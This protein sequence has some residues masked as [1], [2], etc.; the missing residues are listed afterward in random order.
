MDPEIQWIHPAAPELSS[1]H[2]RI[3]HRVGIISGFAT[4]DPSDHTYAVLYLI[5]S[6]FDTAGPSD[7]IYAVLY[8]VISG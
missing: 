7:R 5:I 4:T 1:D 6:G 2:S 3:Y 8:L